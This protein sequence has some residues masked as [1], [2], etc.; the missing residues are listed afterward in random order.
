MS[1]LRTCDLHYLLSLNAC[2][3]RP[4]YIAR[5]LSRHLLWLA[6]LAVLLLP[7][8]KTFAD[9]IDINAQD[10]Q[11]MA[12]PIESVEITLTSDKPVYEVGEPLSATYEI[13]STQDIEARSMAVITYSREG[14]TTPLVSFR[15]TSLIP[16]LITQRIKA[17]RAFH[18]SETKAVRDLDFF[19]EAG[20][21]HYK[22]S[23]YSCNRIREFFK[24]QECPDFSSLPFSELDKIQQLTADKEATL[25]IE[26]RKGTRILECST[27]K[28]C[29]AGCTNCKT[30]HQ[31]CRWDQRKCL[32]CTSASDCVSGYE[33]R[34][35]R[36]IDWECD[37]DY[38]CSDN[39]LAT[40]NSCDSHRCI[41]TAK[42][43]CIDNDF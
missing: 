16:G 26:V 33:C 35:N 34:D 1:V 4:M 15:L 25:S 43:S 6:V 36:C 37:N 10:T 13:S 8:P 27:D 5:T 11:E 20:V 18:I 21:Y 7:I 2:P 9:S 24:E 14:F 19:H 12:D 3:S 41:Y 42:T 38:Q 32:Q 28:D 29:D 23:L 22:L 17:L 40:N 31:F 30:G 39:D